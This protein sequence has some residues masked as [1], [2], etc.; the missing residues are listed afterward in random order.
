MCFERAQ[1]KENMMA[2]QNQN[3]SKRSPDIVLPIGRPLTPAP[4]VEWWLRLMMSRK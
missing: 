1:S 4:G 3:T 2:D